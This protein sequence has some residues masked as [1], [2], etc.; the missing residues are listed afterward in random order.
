MLRTFVSSCF[1]DRNY[2]ARNCDAKNQ[3]LAVECSVMIRNLSYNLPQTQ[4]FLKNTKQKVS[5]KKCNEAPSFC[6]YGN[7]IVS[8]FDGKLIL[9]LTFLKTPEQREA[10]SGCFK[11]EKQRESTAKEDRALQG[12]KNNYS[13]IGTTSCFLSPVYIVPPTCVHV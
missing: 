2:S 11:L 12:W 1:H 6:A 4:G 10:A 7:V 3:T 8:L 9:F 5:L 13:F